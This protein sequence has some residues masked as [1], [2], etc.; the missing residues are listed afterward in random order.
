MRIKK[1]IYTIDT[2]KRGLVVI[3]DPH[4]L[5]Q[6]LQLYCMQDYEAEWDALCLPKENGKEEMSLYCKRTNIFSNIYKDDIEYIKLPLVNKVMLFLDMFFHALIGKKRRFFEKHMNNYVPDVKK[7]D[8]FVGNTESGFITGMLALMAPEKEVVY[9]EDGTA[10]YWI[11]RKKWKSILK[12]PFDNL[13]AVIMARLGYFG[14]GYTWLES[15]KN[16]VKYCSNKGELFYKNFREI[17]E[18]DLSYEENREYRK[19]IKE[20]YPE[21]EEI[22]IDQ[23]SVIVFTIPND[24]NYDEW[25]EYVRIFIDHICRNAKKLILKCHP[26]DDYNAYQFPDSVNVY[27]VPRDIPGELLLDLSDSNDCY[28]MSAD[29]MVLSMGARHNSVHI[30]YNSQSD[31]EVM[32][33]LCKRFLGDNYTFERLI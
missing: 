4:A 3:Y 25:D 32:T 33:D 9:F 26:R 31:T 10:D 23:E 18:F 28:L 8:I 7:Y 15:T 19:L 20:V 30:L 29:S 13:Q 27:V 6:F 5:V 21:L 11:Y 12:N 2:M 22:P 1:G 24:F 17:R 16:T 14:K